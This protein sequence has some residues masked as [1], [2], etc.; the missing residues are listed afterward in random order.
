[1]RWDSEGRG[2]EPGFGGTLP[3]PVDHRGKGPKDFRRSDE[4]LR[5]DVCN[6][7]TEH[8]GVDASDMTVQVQRGE[9]ILLGTVAERRMK[10]LAEDCIESIRGV[11]DIRN[12]LR[13]RSR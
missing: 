12:H 13:V 5:E 2:P 9:V 10:H 4:S 3:S 8:P 6:L 11:V 7:L 1:M